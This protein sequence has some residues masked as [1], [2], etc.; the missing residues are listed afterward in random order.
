MHAGLE[1]PL[2]W[3]VAHVYEVRLGSSSILG[4]GG[5]L[6]IPCQHMYPD[7][8]NKAFV[9]TDGRPRLKGADACTVGMAHFLGLDLGVTLLPA[10]PCRNVTSHCE[11]EEVQVHIEDGE[12]R[13]ELIM[14]LP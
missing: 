6:R 7:V 14:K 12:H 4:R 11:R 2:L 13:H 1:S 9:L 3:V 8:R 5:T 10:G